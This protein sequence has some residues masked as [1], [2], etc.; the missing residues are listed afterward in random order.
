MER[1]RERLVESGEG[2]CERERGERESSVERK[3]ESVRERGAG[4]R[5]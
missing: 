2:E 1:E 5:K 3:R 4:D